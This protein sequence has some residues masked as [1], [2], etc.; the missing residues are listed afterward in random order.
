MEP[1]SI[2]QEGF[3]AFHRA[4]LLALSLV[5]VVAV[6]EMVRRGYLKE[7]YALLWLVA[8]GCGL[9][10]GAFPQLIV[11]LSNWFG[12]QY[13]TTVYV[14]SFLFLMGIV[15][16]FSIVISSLSEKSRN[17]AQEL[18]LLDERIRRLEGEER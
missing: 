8:S 12:F 2:G 4:G 9:V 3:Y 5:L 16:V 13:L 7:R 1:N 6:L 17:L 18:A 14:L 11:H 10:V 15:L